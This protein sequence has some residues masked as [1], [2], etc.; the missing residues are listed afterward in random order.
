MAPKFINTQH[1]R[2]SLDYVARGEVDAGFVY[3]TDARAMAQRVK[4]LMEVP[5][6]LPITYPIA[7]VADTRSPAVARRFVEFV[8]SS[9]AKAILKRH[10]FAAP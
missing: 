1:V 10:G 3:A 8:D 4:V 5:L 6:D 9:Q 2:Q 7:V